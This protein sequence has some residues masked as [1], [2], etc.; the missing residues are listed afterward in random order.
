MPGRPWGRSGRGGERDD[1][2]LCITRAL[3]PRPQSHRF[4][5]Q[6]APGSRKVVQRCRHPSDTSKT[7]VV[8]LGRLNTG[9]I[10]G[11]GRQSGKPKIT[12]LVSRQVVVA[13]VFRGFPVFP[14]HKSAYRRRRL[15]FRQSFRFCHFRSACCAQESGFVAFC[16]RRSLS[17][18]RV[19]IHGD[20]CTEASGVGASGR[21]WCRSAQV[22]R[23]L[24]WISRRR[25]VTIGRPFMR[26]TGQPS[27]SR[28][29]ITFSR[30]R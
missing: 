19:I 30:C 6:P 5:S 3:S 22:R 20:C 21:P 8:H 10:G 27:L 14:L 29:I 7:A 2:A 17:Q 18:S 24:V 1:G 12:C 13:N 25:K 23:M 16:C 28:K 26:T 4:R 11:V 15:A 9:G